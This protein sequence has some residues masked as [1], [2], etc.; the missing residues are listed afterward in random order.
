MEIEMNY[1]KLA[2]PFL[3]SAT[4]AVTGCGR[5]AENEA[6]VIMNK[7]AIRET[8]LEPTLYCVPFCS[9]FTDIIRYKT[10]TDT[11]TISS[12]QEGATSGGGKTPEAA[13]S[14]QVFLRSSDDKFIES[15]SLS[16][17]TE[18]VKTPTIRKLVTEF[19]ADS[20]DAEYN[21][22][23]IRDDLQILIT[24]P[25][26][27][28]IRSYEALA[29][30]DNGTNI[31]KKLVTALQEAIDARLEIKKGEVSPIRVKSVVLG[32][33]KFDNE[34]EAILKKKIFAKEQGNIADEANAAAA[35]Q[36]QAANLQAG[37][38]ANI[39]EKIKG[40]GA[41]VG[42]VASLVC[43]D[44]KRQKLLDEGTAC[45]PSIAIK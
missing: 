34:T 2:M 24:Q 8:V 25:L 29:I 40:A 27:D 18:V 33:V 7:G 35:K 6:A 12:G 16:I 5:V 23:L 26:V 10:F 31:G 44:M 42:E 9:P 3:L 1:K 28:V 45:F 15:V 11:F 20:E 39:I 14:R 13:Q 19:R 22:E 36:A 41:P 43:L 38:T 30:Q 37:V 32:G 4:V 21:T 17:S